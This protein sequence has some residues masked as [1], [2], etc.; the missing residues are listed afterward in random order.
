M[1][2]TKP[3]LWQ[4]IFTKN[5]LLCIFTGFS[6]GLPLYVLFQLV[7]AWLTSSNVDVKTIGFFTL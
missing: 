6:S 5:M 2:A 4:Q 3:S 7:P 1:T